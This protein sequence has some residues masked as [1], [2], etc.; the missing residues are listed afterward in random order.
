MGTWRK[1]VKIRILPLYANITQTSQSPFHFML[2]KFKRP[3]WISAARQFR[4]WPNQFFFVQFLELLTSF[5][6]GLLF[7]E[8]SSSWQALQAPLVAKSYVSLL[9]SPFT[10]CL[11]RWLGY[12]N[13]QSLKPWPNGLA[14]SRKHLQV[15]LALGGQTSLQI[16]S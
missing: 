9:T 2:G 1:A 11:T 4:I 13:W 16:S 3:A 10:Y 15:E 8:Y 5:C 12:S 6:S 14:S 7:T